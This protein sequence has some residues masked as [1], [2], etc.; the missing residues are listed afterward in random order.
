M[1]SGKSFIYT[2]NNRGPKTDPWR[3]PA[4]MFAEEVWPLSTTLCSLLLK[5][6]GNIFSRPPDMPFILSLKR[7]PS[8]LTLS[9]ALD[10]S[11]K[12]LLISNPSSKDLQIS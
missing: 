1:P 5:K 11:K 3:T 4:V 6:S 12:T 9:K 2:K 8:M 7:N 10:I